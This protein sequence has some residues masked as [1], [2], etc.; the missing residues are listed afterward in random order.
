[1]SRVGSSLSFAPEVVGAL[2]PKAWCV[3][4]HNWTISKK[5][6]LPEMGIARVR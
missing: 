6:L 5:T 1:M 2:H 3:H 4:V